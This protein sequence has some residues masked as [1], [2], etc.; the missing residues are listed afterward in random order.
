MKLLY[1][2]YAFP[3]VSTGSAPMN[4]YLSRF[5]PEA[6]WEMSVVS[7]DNPVSLPLDKSLLDQLPGEMKVERIRHYDP[8]RF[9]AGLSGRGSNTDHS[10]EKTCSYDNVSSRMKKFL[11]GYLLIPDRAITWLPNALHGTIRHARKWQVDLIVVCGPPHSA[12]LTA[13]LACS[14]LN[15][16][17]VNYFGDLWIY[18]SYKSSQTGFNNRMQK[19]LERFIVSRSDGIVTTTPLSSRYFQDTYDS[20]CPEVFTVIN[21][22]DPDEPFNKNRIKKKNNKELIITYTGFFMGTQTPEPFL[23]G[24]AYFLKNYPEAP[25]RFRSVGGFPTECIS[26]VRDLGIKKHVEITGIVPFV[27][28]RGYQLESDIL[29][30]LLPDIPGSEVKNASKT[31]EYLRTGRTILAVTP[32]GDMTNFVTELNAGYVSQPE[33]E[34]VASVLGEVFND[35]KSGTL[36]KPDDQEAIDR[37]FNM[38]RNVINLGNF[39]ET[40]VKTSGKVKK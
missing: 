1:L 10:T 12:H 5:L 6:G 27:Q 31:A 34:S 22:Y 28:V 17:M 15:L 40:V 20:I 4:L 26:L 38:R 35:W 2:S 36:K 32:K 14:Y 39:L 30:L 29:L 19:K 9:L 25:V 21:G 7:A 16:P 33:P 23:R 18:D 11:Y 13:W 24:L 3:P 37:I 8:L